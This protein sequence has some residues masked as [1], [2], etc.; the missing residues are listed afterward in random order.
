MTHRARSLC[1][2]SV[3]LLSAGLVAGRETP[4]PQTVATRSLP[5]LARAAD[6]VALVQVKDTDYQYTRRFP[7]GGTAFLQVLIAY[8]TARP[9][10]DLLEVY[11]EGLHE[12]ACY[13]PDPTV[14]EEGR[15]Y[16]VFL[17]AS[18][19]VAGQYNGLAQG[20]A[21]EALVTET[22]LY[23]LRYPLIGMALDS[24][25]RAS[26]Q[27]LR[28]A[29]AHAVFEDDSLAPGLR[30]AW[31]EAGWIKRDGNRYR[32]A[33]GIDLSAARQLLGADLLTRARGLN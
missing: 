32:Y 1:L 20:C 21:L 3:L 22:N 4:P 25:Y 26:A 10:E 7:S 33:W 28:F 19:D 11:E 13:F 9:L 31:L 12:H 18:R 17:R 24:D 27:T 2:A 29:D 15:R 6:V 5:Q 14:F 23:A 30:K 8:K 16:L